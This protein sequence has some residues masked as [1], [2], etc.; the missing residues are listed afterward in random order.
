MIDN[1]YPYT[2]FHELNLDWI[3]TKIKEVVEE[4][5]QV[6]KELEDV[7]EIENYVKNYL[8]NLDLYPLISDKIDSLINDGSFADIVQ[9]AVQENHNVNLSMFLNIP[10]NSKKLTEPDAQKAYWAQG[11]CVC[12][13]GTFVG[14]STDNQGFCTIERYNNNTKEIDLS[15]DLTEITHPNGMCYVE[16]T[17]S[18]Y[19]MDSEHQILMILSGSD[20]TT[21]S[22]NPIPLTRQYRSIMYDE[23]TKTFYMFNGLDLY[24]WNP[25]TT[26]TTKVYSLPET[27]RN[28]KDGTTH[29]IIQSGCIHNGILYEVSNSPDE[30]VKFELATGTL[31]YE[32]PLAEYYNIYPVNEIESLSWYNNKL[33]ICS[34][35]G[36]SSRDQWKTTYIFETDLRFNNGIDKF[37]KTSNVYGPYQFYVDATYRKF[38]SDGSANRPFQT[39]SQ[40]IQAITS[41]VADASHSYQVRLMSDCEEYIYMRGATLR[42][43]GDTESRSILGAQFEF[44]SELE[45]ENITFTGAYQ[46]TALSQRELVLQNSKCN[47]I[48][49]TF[50]TPSKT[51]YAPNTAG[52]ITDSI[53]WVSGTNSLV[54]FPLWVNRSQLYGTRGV[55]T[56]AYY[57]DESSV[58]D[59]ILTVPTN[60]TDDTVTITY[61]G[62]VK[63]SLTSGFFDH[64]EIKAYSTANSGNDIIDL[65]Y[66]ISCGSGSRDYNQCCPGAVG[67]ELRIYR[68]KGR[69]YTD[70]MTAKIDGWVNNA[71]TST[72]TSFTTAVPRVI[73]SI[74]FVA[75]RN[76]H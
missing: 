65:Y 19:V 18:L 40:A 61:P 49:C 45:I 51:G 5:K 68:C 39:I 10:H 36:T 29:G 27:W 60:A 75:K 63:H 66:N 69:F 2:D 8:E 3:I 16:E 22:T 71:G 53:M 9:K 72:H 35:S 48:N 21:K 74:K 70:Y 56:N 67:S 1:R 33:Y 13:R 34:L 50:N 54:D 55:C 7:R 37:N 58:N 6:L 43:I 11:S 57:E 47:L 46:Y 30:I 14:Y 15:R 62:N 20:L 44:C 23:Q 28:T 12:S 76:D 32:Y 31:I 26:V 17:D 25:E 52:I 42:L 41:P 73:T 64:V 4:N 59:A 24:K 38:N